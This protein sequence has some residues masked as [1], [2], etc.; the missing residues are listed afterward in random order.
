MVIIVFGVWDDT[1]QV[2][3]YVKFFGQILAITIVVFYG[4]VWIR[5]LPFTD[6]DGVSPW[7]GI[8]FT[9]FAIIGMTNAVNTSDGLDGMAGGESLLG[10]IVIA[11]LA[12]IADGIM[13]C[14]IATSCIGGVLGFLRFMK[15]NKKKK[16]TGS[17]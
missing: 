16:K 14:V 5:H 8:P 11:F 15:Q 6:I 3:P 4:D 9:Y 17:M 13:A 2:G 7:I 12:Y 10:L 1:R